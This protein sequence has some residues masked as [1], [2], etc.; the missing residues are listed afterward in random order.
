MKITI[1]LTDVQLE[2]TG[3]GLEFTHVHSL[4]DVLRQGVESLERQTR[5]AASEADGQRESQEQ[6]GAP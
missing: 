1:K 6:G 4:I 2:L 5:E 3:R